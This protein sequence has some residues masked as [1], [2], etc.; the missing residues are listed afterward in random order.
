[1]PRLHQFLYS[2]LNLAIAIFI[3]LVLLIGMSLVPRRRE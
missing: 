1:M 2:L 3:G